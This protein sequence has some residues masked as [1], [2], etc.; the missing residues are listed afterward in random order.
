[1]ESIFR[2]DFCVQWYYL[3]YK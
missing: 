1:L 2:S 3:Y